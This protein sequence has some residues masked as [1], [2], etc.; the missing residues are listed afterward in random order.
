[1]MPP[2]TW[3]DRFE[4]WLFVWLRRRDAARQLLAARMDHVFS[5]RVVYDG[6]E[7]VVLDDECGVSV[8]RWDMDFACGKPKAWHLRKET[9]A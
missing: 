5:P 4:I 9:N 8:G 1:M 3:F 6:N 2:L 7:R